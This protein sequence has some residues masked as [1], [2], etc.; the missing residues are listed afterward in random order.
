MNCIDDDNR[1]SCMDHFPFVPTMTLN[2][3]MVA[4]QH[5]RH[6]VGSLSRARRLQARML[7]YYTFIDQESATRD[8]FVIGLGNPISM[9]KGAD[10]SAFHI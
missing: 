1:Q 5:V 3:D 4:R 10:V 9:L 7:K 2:Q 8:R 6:C